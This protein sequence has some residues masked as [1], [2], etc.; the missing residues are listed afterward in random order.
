M[1]IAMMMLISLCVSIRRRE[2]L[3]HGK[4]HVFT[5][6]RKMV[7][8][9]L[10]IHKTAMLYNQFALYD[11]LWFSPWEW[12]YMVL[13]M[14]QLTTTAVYTLIYVLITRVWLWL[15]LGVDRCAVL[16]G[17]YADLLNHGVCAHVYL[18]WLS[19][20]CGDHWICLCANWGIAG[21]TTILQKF[22]IKVNVWN[23]VISLSYI[24]AVVC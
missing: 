11:R 12:N 8:T 14:F 5:G 23:E 6:E 15:L 9:V 13:H 17:V 24:I 1:N 22:C 19:S 16:C 21:S 4:D 3:V 10:Y 7:F 18:P 2:Q 20:V